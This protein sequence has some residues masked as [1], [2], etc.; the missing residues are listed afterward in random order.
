[1]NFSSLADYAPFVLILGGIAAASWILTRLAK[2][3]PIVGKPVSWFVKILSLF[4]FLIGILMLV[5]AASVWLARAWDPGTR[6][7]LILAGLAL[8]LKPMKNIPWA[9][10]M[11][12]IVG[13]LCTGFVYT[14]YPLP[15]TVFGISSTWIYLV[16]FLIPAL[17]AYL[18][19]QFIEDVLRLIGMI[20]AFKPIAIVLGLTC[21]T[22]GILMLLKMSLFTIILP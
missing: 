14:A 16:I 6:Y 21:I 20:L 4:G 22:Q 11:G 13:A 8:F 3:A 1:M 17:S 15:E 19:F 5:T 2:P 9:A 7:L 18:L 12:L 10:L